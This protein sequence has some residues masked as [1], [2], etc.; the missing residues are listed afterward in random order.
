MIL[1]NLGDYSS[2]DIFTLIHSLLCSLLLGKKPTWAI[3]GLTS[4]WIEQ[5]KTSLGDWWAEKWEAEYSFIFLPC[6]RE[7]YPP[8]TTALLPYS[9][10]HRVSPS[11]NYLHPAYL[12]NLPFFKNHGNVGEF[13]AKIFSGTIL[14]RFTHTT[15]CKALLQ[16]L[17]KAKH[18]KHRHIHTSSHVCLSTS[19]L[20]SF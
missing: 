18:V 4:S 7:A 3:W 20:H 2:F 10:S 11:W 1:N 8:M 17:W 16:T 9:N 5:W 13:A 15:L 19:S 12:L 6:C 14:H